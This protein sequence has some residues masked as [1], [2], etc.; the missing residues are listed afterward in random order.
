MLG[1]SRTS[2]AQAREA[3]VSR[4][5]QDGFEA[6]GAE[7]LSVATLLSSSAQLRSVLTDTQRD[8]AQRSAVT[9][10]LLGGKVGELT[11]DI[12]AETAGLRW[13][14]SGDLVEAIENLGVDATLIT[15]ENAGRADT[16]ED[17]LFRVERLV[18]GDRGITE[19]LTQPGVTDE[20]KASLLDGI[21]DGKVAPETA[22]LVR[23]VVAHPRGRRP[24]RALAE[25]V[26]A[27]AK[28][29]ERLLA[30]LRVVAPLTDQ[31]HQRLVAVLERIYG[32]PVD[33]QVEIDP[34]V[35]GGVIV[36]VGDEVIDGSVAHRLDNI[37]RL[38]GAN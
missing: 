7:L 16:V 37:R 23:H 35:R 28:R 3:L 22:A 6:V 27:A 4:S 21:L 29:R 18:A 2:V 8:A 11:A 38:M 10:S 1:A 30:K 31:Q 24:Q 34:D 14:R 26:D 17:E 5:D 36:Q 19:A 32:R 25:L 20:A 13:T 12:V 9:K 15:A 33:M